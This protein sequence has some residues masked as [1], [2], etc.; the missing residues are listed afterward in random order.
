MTFSEVDDGHRTKSRE[1]Q[2]VKFEMTATTQDRSA[3]MARVTAAF[4]Q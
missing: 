4:L 1:T 3:G 2:R